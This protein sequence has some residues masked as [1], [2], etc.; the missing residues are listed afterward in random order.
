L[1]E[2]E[3][4]KMKEGWGRRWIEFR[5][6]LAGITVCILLAGWGP[7]SAESASTILSSVDDIRAPGP[8][9][10][11]DLVVTSKPAGRAP[12]VQKF[13]VVVKDATKSLVKYTD[14]VE[15]RGRVLLMIGQ[16]FWLYLP[17]TSQPVRISAQQRM[18]GQISNGD[19]ARVVYSYD[20]SAQIA[21]TEKLGD[22]ICTR[23]ELKS[24]TQ[25]AAYGRIVLWVDPETSRPYQG[26]FYAFTGK[27]LKTALYKGYTRVL[28]R[29]RPMVVEVR[30][31][32]RKGEESLM[33]YS[34]LRI[35]NT[36]DSQFHKENL[37]DVR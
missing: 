22:H 6:A 1:K 15:T 12:V 33:Q 34:N 31:E 20:Y 36:P 13:G 11:F 14:P 27:L 3:G 37:R 7:P 32:V 25:E 8:N 19:V 23:L 24:K 5:S 26:Q 4:G 16:D 35:V 28:G 10:A 21:G 18:L 30:D 17:T 29:E 9:F 2:D